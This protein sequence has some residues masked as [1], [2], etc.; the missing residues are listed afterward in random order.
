MPAPASVIAPLRYSRS[1]VL[2]TPPAILYVAVM[3][4][5]SSGESPGW[6]SFSPASSGVR[7]PASA[8]TSR[9]TRS[10]PTPTTLPRPIWSWPAPP[11][12]RQGSAGRS[13]ASPVRSSGPETA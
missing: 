8:A 2:T 6:G 11:S 7:T 10:A 5:K 1:S 4:S 9:R 12:V 13:N 3:A